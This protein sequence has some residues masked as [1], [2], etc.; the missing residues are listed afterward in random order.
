VSTE[1][2]CIFTIIRFFISYPVV[3]NFIITKKFIINIIQMYTTTAFP[4]IIYTPTYFDILYLHQGVTY[5]LLAK[6]HKFLARSRYIDSSWNVMAHGDA[7]VGK[8]RG[9]LANG[10]GSQ[11]PSH[12]LG[13]WRIQHYR[14]QNVCF[15]FLYNFCLEHFLF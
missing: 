8:W 6:V 7:R 5:L 15:D 1:I 14:A 4:C 10:V 3:F 11:F 12:Y 9:K 13:T 2:Y